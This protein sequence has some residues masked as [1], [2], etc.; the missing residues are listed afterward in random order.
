VEPAPATPATAP[1]EAVTHEE[2]EQHTGH[3]L[4]D[5]YGPPLQLHLL[6]VG[7]TVAMA[8]AALGVSFRRWSWR[9][10]APSEAEQA[11]VARRLEPGAAPARPPIGAGVYV[12]TTARQEAVAPVVRPARFW[13]IACLLAVA[14]AVV[15]IWVSDDWK[16]D[17]LLTPLR[18]RPRLP[19][20]QR[21][22]YHVVFGLS[23]VTLTLLL[24]IIT[25]VTRRAK[26]VT[27]I[28]ALLL[29]L[30]TAAQV[31]LGILL[32]FDTDHGPLTG[33]NG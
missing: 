14:T 21:M 2:A 13:L 11:E 1:V 22:F 23:I 8:L 3:S 33:F 9:P 28:F 12:P 24:A 19:E 26:A 16:L 5:Y 31:W 25:R 17:S 20:L 6:L 15:G 18:D 27:L 4:V 32:L 10:P 7:L 29:V 30:A